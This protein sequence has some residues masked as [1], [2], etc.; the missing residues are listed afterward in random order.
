M[1]LAIPFNWMMITA[2]TAMLT[3]DSKIIHNTDLN[4][5]LP[6]EKKSTFSE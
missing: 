3:S 2:P 4:G 6:K 1:P 5:K